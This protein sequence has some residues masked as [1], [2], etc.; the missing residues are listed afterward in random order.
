M[1][2]QETRMERARRIAPH[3]SLTLED[4]LE[5]IEKGLSDGEIM[6]VAQ[7]APVDGIDQAISRVLRFMRQEGTSDA[8]ESR[9][10]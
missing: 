7:L 9:V 8:A 4:V 5:M 1:E 2:A 3:V 6:H 10:K